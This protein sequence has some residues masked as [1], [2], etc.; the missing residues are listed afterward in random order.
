M[1]KMINQPSDIHNV[2][3]FYNY[4]LSSKNKIWNILNTLKHFSLHYI[5]YY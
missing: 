1:F 2:N 5:H 3:I 4:S